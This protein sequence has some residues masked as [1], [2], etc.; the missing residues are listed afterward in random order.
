MVYILNS[1][2]QPQMPTNR[3][4][5]AK[6]VKKCSPTTKRNKRSPLKSSYFQNQNFNLYFPK[7]MVLQSA[8]S[9]ALT[10]IRIMPF[11]SQQLV[12]QLEFE[13][14]DRLIAEATVEIIHISL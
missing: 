4:Y 5:K 12:E 2:R 10:Y 3:H 13:G 11:T 6:V 8:I 14:F 9:I 7:N 1:T